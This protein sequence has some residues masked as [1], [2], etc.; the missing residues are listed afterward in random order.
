MSWLD[1]HWYRLTPL[2]VLLAPLAGLYCL[3]VGLRRTLYRHG[4]LPS[5]RLPVAVIVVGNLTVGGTGKTPLVL[6]LVRFLA[7]HGW[8]PGIVTRGYRGRSRAWP[9]R[10]R[11]DSDPALV[12]DEP[13]LLARHA[14]C[15]VI[16]DPD[17]V[18][19]ARW[20]IAEDHC[21]VIVADDGLQHYR[22]GRDIEIALIDGV[23]RFG[24]GLCLP[25]GP[26]RE[27]VS[28]LRTVDVRLVLGE[29]RAD[30]EWGMRLVVRGFHRLDGG[31]Q[32]EAEA[33]CGRRVHAV[34]G[35][36]H[37]A[38][39]FAQLRALGLDIIAHAFAD[40]YRYRAADL[41]FGDAADIIMTE[42]DAVKCERLGL[43]PRVWY[44]AVEAEPDPRLGDR[45]LRLLEEKHRG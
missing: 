15:P 27:P 3:A 45:V 41:A 16:A 38:R 43:G 12:G 7:E 21:N 2:S 34:A 35:I 17:R 39:F 37:P 33:F 30:D 8:R 22:L 9:Q 24:N 6:W 25:A 18:R 31:G 1:R 44:L 40:H 19:A 14:G 28:R 29:P 23:R 36:G 26:L 5:V 11:A 20:L 4:L 42:K 32:A 10:V 13:V